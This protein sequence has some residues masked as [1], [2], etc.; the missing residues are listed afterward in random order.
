M[1]QIQLGQVVATES[2]GL[3]LFE[4]VIVVSVERS[5]IKYHSPISSERKGG[6]TG[7]VGELDRG[8]A[9]GNI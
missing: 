3:D 6:E 5:K 8:N 4:S 9:S 2:A 1:A 7:Q